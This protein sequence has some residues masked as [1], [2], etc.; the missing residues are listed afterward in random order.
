MNTYQFADKPLSSNNNTAKPCDA[1]REANFCQKRDED[2]CASPSFVFRRKPTSSL[3]QINHPETHRKLPGTNRFTIET[4]KKVRTYFD[5]KNA[6]AIAALPLKPSS[7]TNNC[8]PLALLSALSG[9]DLERIFEL[10]GR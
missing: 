5:T 2:L 6:S 4:A 1:F 7:V 3:V 10:Y 8:T 9:T